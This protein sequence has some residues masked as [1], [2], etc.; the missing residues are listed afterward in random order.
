M[1]CCS[2][3][4]QSNIFA[5]SSLTSGERLLCHSFPTTSLICLFVIPLGF[6][7]PSVSRTSMRLVLGI[8]CSHSHATIPSSSSGLKLRSNALCAA[9]YDSLYT[10]RA[11]LLL[12]ILLD[13][14]RRIF[15]ASL[16]NLSFIRGLWGGSFGRFAILDNGVAVRADFGCGGYVINGTWSK[17]IMSS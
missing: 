15:T 5:A 16:M 12:D 10:I 9:L 1:T 14:S 11:E 6:A 2:I 3:I 4:L 17:L 13:R 8:P 7:C